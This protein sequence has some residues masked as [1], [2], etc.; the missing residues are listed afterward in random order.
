VNVWLFPSFTVMGPDGAMVPFGPAVAVMVCVVS[1][2]V[3]DQA[4]FAESAL[5]TRSFAPVVM[6]AV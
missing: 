6:V 4:S 5:P 2:V 3:N 1:T